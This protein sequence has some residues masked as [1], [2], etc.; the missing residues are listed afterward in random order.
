MKFIIKLIDLKKDSVGI[1]GGKASNLGELMRGG[2]PVPD[3][4]CVNSEGFRFYIRHNHLENAITQI[5]E[6]AKNENREAL[7][8]QIA[9][10]KASIVNG[11][12][13]NELRN[14]I[15]EAF[16][17][18]SDE[19]RLAIRS[20]AT[21]EDLKDA[22]FAGQ[23]ETYLGV[24]GKEN[25]LQAIQKCFASLYE[26][27]AVI[28]RER[29]GYHTA[30]A[31]LAVVVQEMID[32]E[33]AGVIFTENP[34]NQNADE[35]MINASYGLG[36]SVVSGKVTPD[37]YICGKENAEIRSKTAG[38]KECISTITEVI[39]KTKIREKLV[40]K[41]QI[42]RIWEPITLAECIMQKEKH[43]KKQKI[44]FN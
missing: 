1:G 25:L 12:Y 28:Y 20:S 9:K 31:A 36:E 13:P 21:A 17:D 33:T 18:I 3:G 6:A 5:A 29:M 16:A 43:P 42:R 8:T 23:Q 26:E 15:L 44:I 32:S 19:K 22:S 24:K 34:V 35:M 37:I 11:R 30:D 39:T 41:K 10:L 7:H 2:F 4:F 27:R 38:T 40:P 14:E